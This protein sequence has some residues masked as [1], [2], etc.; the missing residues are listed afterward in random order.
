MHGYPGKYYS[1]VQCIIRCNIN[2]GVQTVKISMLYNKSLVFTY[3]KASNSNMNAESQIWHL[4][5]Q[6]STEEWCMSW[7]SCLSFMTHTGKCNTQLLCKQNPCIMNRPNGQQC[8][9][10]TNTD[11]SSL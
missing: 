11:N 6:L 3:I 5:N 4:A 7:M 1:E 10:K 2:T 8:L 9:A